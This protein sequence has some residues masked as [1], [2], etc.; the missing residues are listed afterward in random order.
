MTSLNA[1]TLELDAESIAWLTLDKPDSS[2][3]TLG[4]AVLLEL[5]ERI[6]EL[7]QR[8]PRGVIVRS[9]KSSGFVAGADIREFTAFTS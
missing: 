4:R 9:G 5:A 7:E 1:W 6:G 3:N 8:K 2:A